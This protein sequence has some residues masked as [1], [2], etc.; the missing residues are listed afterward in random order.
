[1]IARRLA[2][3]VAA[4]LC[5]GAPVTATAQEPDSACQI[6][7][8]AAAPVPLERPT[9]FATG[10]GVRVAVIDTGVRP[11]EQLKPVIPGGDL[12][13]RDT[14]DPLFDCDGHGTAVAG[15]IA[16]RDQGIAPNAEIISIRQTSAHYRVHDADPTGGSLQTLTEAIHLAL[17]H[18]A[19]VINI[20][21]VACVPEHV[22]K[23]VDVTALRTALRRAEDANAVVVAAS[24]NTTATCLPGDVVFPAHEP[25]VVAVAASDGTHHIADYS[26]P[27]PEGDLAVRAAGHVPVALGEGGWSSG[28]RTATADP[29]RGEIVPF[30]GTSFAAPVVS[31]T[32]ALLRERYPHATAAQ[33]RDIVF[34][35][36]RPH[37]GA[38]V[39]E[40]TLTHVPGSYARPARDVTIA[41]PQPTSTRAQDRAVTSMVV[42][43]LAMFVALAAGGLRNTATSRAGQQTPR[44]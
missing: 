28:L 38:V 33:L 15:I 29:V 23:R 36:A 8:P 30:T 25:T 27:V 12:V 41:A 6:P 19:H 24:G 43:G 21:V 5:F 44:P 32:V 37:G 39:P 22:A 1:M 17:D 2:V 34:Q 18:H 11:H 42:L 31:G 4:A 16:S 14:P 9:E 13:A 3:I 40:E 20:S 10:Q 35:S 7:V 26:M